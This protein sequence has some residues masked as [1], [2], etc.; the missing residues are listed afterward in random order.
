MTR[1]QTLFQIK[2]VLKKWENSK[3]DLKCADAVLTRLE[4]LGY[5]NSQDLIV[6]VNELAP[7][8]VQDED[9][10]P[11]WEEEFTVTYLDGRPIGKK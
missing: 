9:N 4:E 1:R 6:T 8:W 5:V 7:G 10:C 2:K 3:L 11:E